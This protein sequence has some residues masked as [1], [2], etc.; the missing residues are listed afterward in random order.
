[1][2]ITVRHATATVGRQRAGRG[3]RVATGLLIL[4]LTGAIATPAV[5]ADSLSDL[6]SQAR[7]VQEQ[8]SGAQ[9]EIAESK[10]GLDSAAGR[11]QE[12]EQQLAAARTRLADIEVQLAAARE[13]NARLAREL[14]IAQEQLAAAKAEVQ[15][16]ED[17]IRR[18]LKVMGV[19]VREAY[20]QR[21]PLEGLSVVLGSDTASQLSQRL[22]WNTT[23]MDAQS[24]EK[25]RLDALQAELEAA[26]DAQ[27]EIEAQVAADKAAAGRQLAAVAN[28]EAK[29]SAETAAIASLVV[30]NEQNRAAAAVE[31]RADEEAYQALQRE[32]AQLQQE[33]A[34]ETARL[35]AEA[36]ARAREEAARLKAEAEARAREEAARRAAEQTAAAAARVAAQ[37]APAVKA[38]ATQTKAASARKVSS[39]GFIRPVNA[40]PGSPFGMRFHPI[41]KYWRMHNGTDFG[42][43]TGTP[44]YAAK[45][46][47]VLKAGTNGGYGQFVLIGHGSLNGKYVTTGYAHQSKIAVS[48]GQWVEQGQLIGYVGNTGLSTTAHLHLEVRL[49]GVAVDPLNYIP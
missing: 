8:Q 9:L 35:K 1:M 45:A 40:K 17:N 22:Q 26:R 29:A 28:L 18:Q 16:G 48:V 30:A 27:A 41:L 25:A 43:A 32:D 10:A 11:L 37:P 36:E 2:G 14:K 21:T 42:A 20:Q 44:L 46:G 38:P 12:S 5:A 4:V 34:A 31:L 49:D 6:Q 23:I 3:A 13:M 15:R 19:A 47:K 24:A 33:I 39:T 7:A